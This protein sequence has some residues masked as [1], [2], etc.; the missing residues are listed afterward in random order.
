MGGVINALKS[1]SQPAKD[2]HA[3]TSGL[4]HDSFRLSFNLLLGVAGKVFGHKVFGLGRYQSSKQAKAN[5]FGFSR[6]CPPPITLH[7]S[8]ST[9]HHNE[10]KNNKHLREPGNAAGAAS[11]SDVD[12]EIDNKDR[13]GAKKQK[14]PQKQ[15]KAI[16]KCEVA[17]AQLAQQQVAWMQITD[18]KQLPK[19]RGPH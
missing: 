5:M 19:D 13:K 8:P 4:E 9:P 6:C 11:E 17:L 2:T 15:K 14:V 10:H 18:I 7:I 12:S 1:S 3:K 16:V